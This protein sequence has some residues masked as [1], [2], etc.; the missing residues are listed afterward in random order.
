MFCGFVAAAASATAQEVSTPAVEIGLNYSWLHVN[1]SNYDYHRTDN[2]GSG[3]V[4]YNFHSLRRC[5]R[6]LSMVT[7]DRHWLAAD[8]HGRRR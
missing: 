1:S 7:A 5:P 2:G 6:P 3:Y 4:Q 8:R